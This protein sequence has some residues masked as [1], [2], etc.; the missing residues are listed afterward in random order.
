ME[1]T[2]PFGRSVSRR[3][4]LQGASALGTAALLGPLGAGRAAAQPKQGGTLRL[5]LA[6][7]STTDTLDPGILEQVFTQVHA[8]CRHNQL[9]EILPDGSLTGEVAESWEASPDATTWTFKI[10]DGLTFHSGKTVTPDDV[11]ASINYHRGEDSTSVAK[12]IV[13]SVTD[14]AADGSNV[15]VTLENGNADFATLMADYHIA[16]MPGIDGRIDPASSD[17]CGP[18]VH[19]EWEPG[20]RAYVTRNPN[21]WKEGKPYFD[22]VEI[23]SIVDPAARQ[24]AVVSGEVDVIDRVDLQTVGLLQRAP[25]ILVLA[26]SG[27]E[28]YGFPMD[29]RAAPFSD[30]NVR[31]A[32]KYAIDRQE[33]VDKI[34]FGYGEVGNDHP[35]GRSNRYFAADLEQHAYD[36]DKAKFYLKEAGLDTLAVDIH[37]ADAAFAGCVNSA[38]LYSEKAAAGGITL[39]VVREPNDGFWSNVWMV[40]PWSATYWGGRPTEDWM[41]STTYA[42]GAPWN[43]TFWDNDRFNE[44]LVMGRAELDEEKRREIYFEM[45]D[46]VS[47]QGG[48]VIPMFG[49][50]VM[51]HSERIAHPDQVSALWTLDGFRAVERWW[52]A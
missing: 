1:S 34:L 15:V 29:T 43:E 12:P 6:H 32:L 11:I 33:L 47:N 14:L 51:A 30:N 19:Q 16:I 8:Q 48:I 22:A 52:F 42:R 45:Q 28:H 17:G 10:R 7:G 21:Y 9:T 20:V 36:P 27:T 18:F 2:N 41:F 39:N 4:V 49:Q 31:Q 3:S 13:A 50:Y 24:N 37:V 44:L 46:L 5:G 38:L 26:T 35:I 23:L 25:G 40:K